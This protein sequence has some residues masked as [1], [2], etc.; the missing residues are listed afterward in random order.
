MSLNRAHRENTTYYGD[1]KMLKLQ[2]LDPRQFEYFVITTQNIYQVIDFMEVSGGGKQTLESRRFSYG[3]GRK[4]CGSFVLTFWENDIVLSWHCQVEFQ[5]P[6]SA[7][8]VVL[9]PLPDGTVIAGHAIKA[10]AEGEVFEVDDL[11][12]HFSQPLLVEYP[13]ASALFID[14]L[15]APPRYKPLQVEKKEGRL[16]LS[17]ILEELA[18]RWNS[19]FKSPTCSFRKVP[20]WQAAAREIC[21]SYEKDFKVVP[22][23][24]RTDLPSWAKQI[25]LVVN[26]DGMGYFH[27]QNHNFVQATE[28]LNELS[29]RFPPEKTLLCMAGFMGRFDYSSA[30]FDPAEE[31]GGEEAF[32]EFMRVAHRLGFHIMILGNARG[33]GAELAEKHPSLLREAPERQANGRICGFLYDWNRDVTREWVIHHVSPDDARWRKIMI[34]GIGSLVEKYDIDGYFL[35][36]VNS[37]PNDPHQDHYRGLCALIG[38]LRSRYPKVVV[39]G[40][41][42]RDYL[43]PLTPLASAGWE[44]ISAP[45]KYHP[46]VDHVFNRYTRRFMHL[47]IF[48]PDNKWG[49]FP[50]DVCVKPVSV[51][52]DKSM[53]EEKTRTRKYDAGCFKRG[54]IPTLML[55]NWTVDLKSASVGEIF[56]F[57]RCYRG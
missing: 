7:V 42:L 22:F 1:E 10:L 34:D 55:S 51:E 29:E 32:R 16:K 24:E 14:L 11:D 2:D 26:L 17:I 38:E 40:E 20:N 31:L 39:A 23:R 33:I 45:D 13:D 46:L 18:C 15:E 12:H 47:V 36:Q 50:R 19:E 27:E 54:I 3:G 44:D 21:A 53:P 57:A 8:K 56:E 35:D 41:G 28:R 49:V 4:E 43:L 48:S 6:I 25:S 52:D 5:E 30:S 37:C 9:P